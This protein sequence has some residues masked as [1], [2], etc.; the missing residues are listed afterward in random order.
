LLPH[1]GARKQAFLDL[2]GITMQQS[3]TLAEWHC[4]DNITQA[5]TS[6]LHTLCPQLTGPPQG[7]TPVHHINSAS[8]RPRFPHCPLQSCVHTRHARRSLSPRILLGSLRTQ[9][10]CP[11]PHLPA[12][13]A[14]VIFGHSSPNSWCTRTPA[15]PR[16]CRCSSHALPACQVH[17]N[18][19][20]AQHDLVHG[21][22]NTSLPLH[23]LPALLGPTMHHSTTSAS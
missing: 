21:W 19:H 1:S 7:C 15:R 18:H 13:T 5:S 11:G 2:Q 23:A 20:L 4:C 6:S 9:T 16:Q 8:S 12:A 10:S 22:A 3:A 14:Q 17:S